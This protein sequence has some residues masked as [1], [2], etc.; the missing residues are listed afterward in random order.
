MSVQNWI[1]QQLFFKTN[2]SNLLQKDKSK[3]CLGI[4]VHTLVRYVIQLST[5]VHSEGICLYFKGQGLPPRQK[6][7]AELIWCV[8]Q[9]H[10]NCLVHTK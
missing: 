6:L 8:C 5:H 3:D 9:N 2:L 10:N 7:I 4:H 1:S